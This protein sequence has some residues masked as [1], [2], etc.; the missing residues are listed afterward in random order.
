MLRGPDGGSKRKVNSYRNRE[1][2][3]KSGGDDNYRRG[4]R[5]R[6]DRRDDRRR[7]NRGRDGR[8]RG[9]RRDEGNRKTP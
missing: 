8:M 6:D 5:R 9:D 7:D 3:F 2:P 1:N 4:D